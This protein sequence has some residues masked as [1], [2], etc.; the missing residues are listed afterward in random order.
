MTGMTH[1][2]HSRSAESLAENP[3]A[4]QGPVLLD[5]GADSGGLVL[6]TGPDLLGA[7]VEIL[8]GAH[9]V[10]GEPAAAS[11][12][13]NAHGHAHGHSH[14]YEGHAHD[15]SHGYDEG[16]THG[17]HQGRHAEVLVRPLPDG[18]TQPCA[19]YPDLEPGWYTLRVLPQGPWMNAQVQ[20]ATVTTV[21][22][23]PNRDSG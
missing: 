7:E 6:H 20:A 19:V 15:H 14:G 22:W 5:I 3:Y 1:P 17:R 8:P 9:A 21:D 23:S 11:G 4:G 13:G 16:H 2:V 18:S 12:H 10:A